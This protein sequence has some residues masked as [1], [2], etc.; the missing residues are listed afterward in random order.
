M[1]DLVVQ[2]FGQPIGRLAIAPGGDARFPEDWL[3]QYL[4]SYVAGNGVP[5]SVSLPLRDAPHV[6]AVARNWF[7]NLLRSINELVWAPQ[8]T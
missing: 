5:L 7:A 8:A 4:P 3:F 6:G 2:L 1:N